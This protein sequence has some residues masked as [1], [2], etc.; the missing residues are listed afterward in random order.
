MLRI[1]VLKNL[2]TPI[3]QLPA[4][5]NSEL[6]E[7]T[8]ILATRYLLKFGQIGQYSYLVKQALYNWDNLSEPKKEY[9]LAQWIE[10]GLPIDLYNQIAEWSWY[11]NG[12]NCVISRLDMTISYISEL[13]PKPYEAYFPQDEDYT[14]TTTPDNDVQTEILKP[15]TPMFWYQTGIGLGINLGFLQTRLKG[16]SVTLLNMISWE[17]SVNA[18]QGI[19]IDLPTLEIDSQAFMS[20]IFLDIDL[21]ELS[22]IPEILDYFATEEIDISIIYELALESIV[23]KTLNTIV[24]KQASGI[25]EYDLWLYQM[26]RNLDNSG[27]KQSETEAQPIAMVLQLILQNP[28]T[29]YLLGTKAFTVQTSVGES[30]SLINT[31]LSISYEA[32]V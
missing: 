29:Q 1:K 16:I 22:I 30:K 25:D 10:K 5:K 12:K 17:N 8:Q 4:E 24:L 18:F 14:Q 20:S 32:F 15:I 26:Q 3:F 28:I 19:D 31:S 13:D 21:D 2:I 6:D 9:L 23:E 27:I 7:E 11:L